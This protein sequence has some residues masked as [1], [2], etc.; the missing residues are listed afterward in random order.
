MKEISQS[1]QID[2]ALTEVACKV[3]SLLELCHCASMMIAYENSAVGDD[4]VML[5]FPF[6]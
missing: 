6:G 2:L 4:A 5:S 3:L 1:D